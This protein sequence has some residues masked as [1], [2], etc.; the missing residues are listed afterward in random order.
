MQAKPVYDDQESEEEE[1][2]EIEEEDEET[3][4]ENMAVRFTLG[5]HRRLV[6]KVVA[7][8]D[9]NSPDFQIRCDFSY[10]IYFFY[11]QN[12]CTG[13]SVGAS[14]SGSARNSSQ[15]TIATLY[16]Y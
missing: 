10:Q 6:I 7:I 3:L 11:F 2:E 16:F 15:V 8:T 9:H 5:Y 14:S 1:E 13:S 4:M 12:G